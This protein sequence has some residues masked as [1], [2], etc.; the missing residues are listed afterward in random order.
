MIFPE[1]KSQMALNIDFKDVLNSFHK[2]FNLLEIDLN[3]CENIPT[4]ISIAPN[5]APL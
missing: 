5:E 3:S 2:S 1:K 4:P